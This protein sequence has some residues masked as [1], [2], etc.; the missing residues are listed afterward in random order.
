L[1]RSVKEYT[2]KLKVLDVEPFK[3]YLKEAY[4]RIMVKSNAREATRLDRSRQLGRIFYSEVSQIHRHKLEL[5]SLKMKMKSRL[6]LFV[7]SLNLK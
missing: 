2:I 1:N 3:G 4:E 6:K 7:M 5:V